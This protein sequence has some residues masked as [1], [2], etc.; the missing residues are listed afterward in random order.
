MF[1][2]ILT[3]PPQPPRLTVRG[4]SQYRPLRPRKGKQMDEHFEDAVNFYLEQG[5]D[6]D[7]ARKLARS[8]IERAHDSRA[9][10]AWEAVQ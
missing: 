1:G 8:A 7:E 6:E 4:L 9:Q 2:L 5:A 3:S 10:D